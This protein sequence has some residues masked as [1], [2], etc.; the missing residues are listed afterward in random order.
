MFRSGHIIKSIPIASSRLLPVW[1][2]FPPVVLLNVG[3]YVVR[4][5][6]NTVALYYWNGNEDRLERDAEINFNYKVYQTVLFKLN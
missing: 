5:F 3:H 6:A 4:S 2:L 1:R